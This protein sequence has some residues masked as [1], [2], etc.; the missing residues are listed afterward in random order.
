MKNRNLLHSD[1]WAT[2]PYFYEKLNKVFNFNFDPC[3]F[4]HD[5][6]EWDGLQIKW[7][8]RNFINPPF[9]L[10]LKTE[11]VKKG[12]EESKKSKLCVFLLPVSTGTKLFHDL[13]LPN[14]HQIGFIKGRLPFIGMNTKGQYVN[15]HLWEHEPPKDAIQIRANG[16]HDNM[17]V[18]FDITESY[19]LSGIAATI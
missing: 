10:K 12:I 8:R 11:F 6:T 19:S 15:W 2:P 14:A 9:N 13:I 3:P 7:K 17:I 16:Q 5:T 4:Q 1:D 18:V